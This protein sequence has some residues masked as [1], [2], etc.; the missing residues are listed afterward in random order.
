MRGQPSHQTNPIE[1]RSGHGP[2]WERPG[3]ELFSGPFLIEKGRGVVGLD[4][5][6]P[7]KAVV[8]CVDEKGQRG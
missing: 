6:F 1:K 7:E 3:N 4:L 2:E 8:L 5:N